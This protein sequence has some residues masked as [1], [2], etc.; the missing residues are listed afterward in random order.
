MLSGEINW[1]KGGSTD[2]TCDFLGD[3]PEWQRQ[4]RDQ[5]N[6]KKKKKEQ[7]GGEANKHSPRIDNRETRNTPNKKPS[8]T[9]KIPRGGVNWDG[10]GYTDATCD[11]LGDNPDW[12]L[13]CRDTFITRRRRNRGGG[14][15]RH[16]QMGR[17][18][19]L[20]RRERWCMQRGRRRLPQT[21]AWQIQAV[22][23]SR[24]HVS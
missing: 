12:Q 10:G 15:G 20:R 14:G 4:C 11:S 21:K 9:E 19:A 22:Y 5:S 7:G 3:N 17:V 8:N 1:E 2:A 24:W 6:N 16:R 18:V 13:Q 23:R